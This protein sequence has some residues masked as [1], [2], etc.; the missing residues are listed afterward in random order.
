MMAKRPYQDH[1]VRRR[2]RRIGEAAEAFT[3]EQLAILGAHHHDDTYYTEAEVD[4][5]LATKDAHNLLTTEV[6]K[7]RGILVDCGMAE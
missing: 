7:I 6:N 1:E 4:G 3:I 5:L 2:D